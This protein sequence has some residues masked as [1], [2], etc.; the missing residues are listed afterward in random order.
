MSCEGTN[1]DALLDQKYMNLEVISYTD[2]KHAVA[3]AANHLFKKHYLSANS[4][5][6]ELTESDMADAL[7]AIGMLIPIFFLLCNYLL[8]RDNRY[9]SPWLLIVSIILVKSG[10]GVPEPDLMLIYGPVR[11]H[12]GF[13]AWR[14]RYTEIV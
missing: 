10:Y 5:K 4:E 2:G 7:A 14:L 11:C 6:P 12:L 13:P 3:R 9:I 8:Y 1:K